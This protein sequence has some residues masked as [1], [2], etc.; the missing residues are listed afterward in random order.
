[1]TDQS[2]QQDISFHTSALD[3]EKDAGLVEEQSELRP[4][5]ES[6]ASVYLHGGKLHFL[7]VGYVQC[8]CMCRAARLT[9]EKD[10]A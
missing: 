7:T 10:F 5:E 3:M 8:V 1:M 4:Q 6:E 2:E 9:I